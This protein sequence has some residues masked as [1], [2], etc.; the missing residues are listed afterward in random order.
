[1]ES[2]RRMDAPFEPT[3]GSRKAWFLGQTSP[4]ANQRLACASRNGDEKPLKRPQT[5]SKRR[6]C[7]APKELLHH[8]RP[9]SLQER[10]TPGPDHSKNGSL[11]ARTTQR[12]DLLPVAGP[13]S[14]RRPCGAPFYNYAS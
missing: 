3:A 9:G 14:K 11:R 7:G 1:M 10:I 2:P 12:P 4:D 8:S 6:P 5:K 13:K